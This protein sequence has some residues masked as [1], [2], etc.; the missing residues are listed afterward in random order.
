MMPEQLCTK[1]FF[2]QMNESLCK[3]IAHNL[4]VVA[5]EVRARGIELDLPTEVLALEDCIKKVIRMRRPQP[6]ELAA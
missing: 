5:R 1:E 3:V 2:T 6:L 4:R